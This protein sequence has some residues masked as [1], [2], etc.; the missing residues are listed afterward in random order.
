MK[1]VQKINHTEYK[2]CVLLI[3]LSLAP[4]LHSLTVLSP[5]KEKEGQFLPTYVIF[6]CV[7]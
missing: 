2:F 1:W 5:C 3:I 6:H 7:T 4:S